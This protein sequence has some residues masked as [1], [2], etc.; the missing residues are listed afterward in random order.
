[1]AELENIKLI[2]CAGLL[3]FEKRYFVLEP[4]TINLFNV[5]LKHEGKPLFE[6]R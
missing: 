5:V 2:D 3:A 6:I 1:M 4:G